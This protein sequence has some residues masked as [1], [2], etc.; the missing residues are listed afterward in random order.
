MTCAETVSSIF[1]TGFLVLAVSIGGRLVYAQS[2]IPSTIMSL[3][4]LLRSGPRELLMGPIGPEMTGRAG[5]GLSLD[6]PS[7]VEARDHRGRVVL[8]RFGFLF[9]SIPPCDFR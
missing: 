5:D 3:S 4:L 1:T 6:T 2:L 8:P 7:R 9:D